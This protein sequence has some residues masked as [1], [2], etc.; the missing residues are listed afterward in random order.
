[1]RSSAAIGLIGT[2]FMIVALFVLPRLSSQAVW[3]FVVIA[4]TVTGLFFLVRWHAARAAYRCPAAA[5]SLRFPPGS[6]F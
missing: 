4:V 2:F 3:P 5:G 1:M 6:I